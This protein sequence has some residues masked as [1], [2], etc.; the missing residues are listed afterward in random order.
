MTRGLFFVIDGVDGC[1][2][3]TQAERLVAALA[4]LGRPAPAHL[5]EA[6]STPLGERLRAILLGREVALVP[7]AETLL[8]CAARAQMLAE[9]VEPALAAGRDVV[10]E[11]F[12]PSTFAY[13]ATAGGLD[14][15]RVAALLD[16]WAGEPAPDL[17]LVLAVDLARAHARVAGR[18]AA[19]AGDRFESRGRA[20]QERV[21]EGLA[22]WVER[23]AGGAGRCVLVDGDGSQDEVHARVMAEVRR[24]L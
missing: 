14:E 7:Q 20:F 11:R 3:T 6:G 23:R 24:A 18:G 10:C 2:K 1:G 19:A 9:V 8:F 12:N 22:R 15:E 21:A 13:Q 16:A 4:G 5:R 17:T